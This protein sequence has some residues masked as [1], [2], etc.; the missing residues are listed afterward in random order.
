MK[1]FFVVVVLFHIA[2]VPPVPIYFCTKDLEINI[3]EE[4]VN[5]FLFIFKALYFQCINKGVP[6]IFL[7]EKIPGFKEWGNSGF[8]F[9]QFS[10]MRVRMRIFLHKDY[11]REG[12]RCIALFE[13]KTQLLHHRTKCK[14]T[15]SLQLSKVEKTDQDQ[16][17]VLIACV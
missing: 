13:R 9:G 11:L 17:S 7:H 4:L 6:L 3:F 5:E 2:G 15:K 10:R 1:D 16:F 12:K 8:I 14:I